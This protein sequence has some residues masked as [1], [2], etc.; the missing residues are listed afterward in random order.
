MKHSRSHLTP[1]QCL[2]RVFLP[3]KQYPPVRPPPLTPKLRVQPIRRSITLNAR[4]IAG[5]TDAEGKVFVSA[6]PLRHLIKDEAIESNAVRVVQDDG[7]LGVPQRLDRLLHQ[8]DRSDKGKV[9]IQL[10]KPNP[11]TEM[12]TVKICDREPLEKAE[13]NKQ[14]ALKQKQ[15]MQKD[16]SPKQIELNWAIS[17]NDL[18]HKMTQ[19]EAFIGKGRK[20][21]IIIA[22]K[23][24][25]RKASEEE[26]NNLLKTLRDKFTEL[27]AKEVSPMEGAV[28]KQAVLM[29]RKKPTEQ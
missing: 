2:L 7:K 26:A 17:E 20:V 29:V 4:S 12:C 13:Y 14:K 1:S 24:R 21:E 6:D 23:R 5:T 11:Q 16:Q 10:S 27:D 15:K 3:A 28:L 19:L 18:L 25:Q 9:I 8:I 22:A